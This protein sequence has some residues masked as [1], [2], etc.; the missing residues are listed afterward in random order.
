MLFEVKSG[1]TSFLYYMKYNTVCSKWSYKK[2]VY[3]SENVQLFMNNAA[4]DINRRKRGKDHGN[5]WASTH[6]SSTYHQSVK[7]KLNTLN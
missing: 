4:N 6:I 3:E 5:K 7:K 2:N 1:F